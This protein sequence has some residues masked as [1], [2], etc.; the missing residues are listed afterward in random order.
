MDTQLAAALELFS[1]FFDEINQPV[2]IIDKD[3]KFVYFN[4]D[5]EQLDDCKAEDVLSKAVPQVFAGLDEQKSTLLQALN[6]GR[7]FINRYQ[8]YFNAAGKEV[9]LAHTTLPLNDSNGKIIGAIEIS[10]D[11]SQINRLQEQF[12]NLQQRIGTESTEKDFGITTNDSEMQRVIHHA[13]RIAKTDVQVLIYGE[14]GTGKELFARLLHRESTRVDKPFIV[15]NCA[16]LPEPL[17][18]STLFGTVR[19]AFTG[20]EDRIGVLETAHGGTLFFDELNSMPLA[21]QGKLLRAL[22]EKTFSRV[23]SNT[24]I[25]V[26]VRI[27]AATNETPQEMLD[28][29]KIRA[30][31]LYRINVGYLAIPPLR[32]R[33]SDIPLLAQ[34]FLR[35]HAKITNQRVTRISN[36]V[37]E[38]L[39]RH[40]WP[41]NVRMLEN[42]VLRSLIM[43]ESGEELDFVLLEENERPFAVKHIAQNDLVV[44]LENSMRSDSIDDEL[45]LDEQI[46]DF[47]KNLLIQYLNRYDNLSEVAR[48][49]GTPRATLQYKLKK[50]GI[51][52]V[53]SVVSN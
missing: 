30:D 22:Q 51:Q 35:K 53:K 9:H 25:K 26:D 3:G 21:I 5:S 24:D 36:A 16:A 44:P 13:Q 12:V 8:L 42:I 47:E 31:L 37:I 4:E 41:G 19:G 7:R 39:K 14:T 45:T 2:M 6:K 52:L 32:D 38:R 46:A 23:G 17:F 28:R 1:E 10:R 15:L 33:V 48:H 49:S 18:E 27:I 29:N 43:C 50:Y 20:A 40:H 34:T 11:L